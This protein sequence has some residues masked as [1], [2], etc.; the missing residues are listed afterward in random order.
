MKPET[1]REDQMKTKEQ[2]DK[3]VEKLTRIRQEGADAARKAPGA[4]LQSRDM[5]YPRD[6]AEGEAWLQGYQSIEK[7]IRI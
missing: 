4:L 7:A 2:Q 1:T 3:W 6:T 5:P